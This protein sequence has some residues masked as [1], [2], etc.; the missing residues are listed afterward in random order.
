MRGSDAARL[1][2]LAVA[3]VFGYHDCCKSRIGQGI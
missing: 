3:A 1:V 2:G